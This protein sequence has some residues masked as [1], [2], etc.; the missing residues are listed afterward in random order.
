MLRT[1]TEQL[2]CARHCATCQGYT[3]EG[4]TDP[5]PSWNLQLS[6]MDGQARGRWQ[7]VC[8]AEGSTW[9]SE[10]TKAGTRPELGVGEDQGGLPGGRD[11][12]HET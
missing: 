4:K 1:F 12:K 10:S 9:C 8:R 2:L 11:V 3:E 6:G 7:A 5:V